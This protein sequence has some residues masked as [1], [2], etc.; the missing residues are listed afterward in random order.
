MNTE[1]KTGMKMD[2][3]MLKA[4]TSKIMK[5]LSFTGKAMPFWVIVMP[6]LLT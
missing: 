6:T 2:G 5:L 3:Q 4:I 1:W